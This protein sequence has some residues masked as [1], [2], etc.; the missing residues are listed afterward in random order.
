MVLKIL[1]AN[2]FHKRFGIRDNL[3]GAYMKRFCK[4]ANPTTDKWDIIDEKEKEKEEIID[5]IMRRLKDE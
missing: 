4:V 1:N 5:E 2:Q 3:G